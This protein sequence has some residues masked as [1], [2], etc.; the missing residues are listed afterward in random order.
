MRKITE[1]SI[2][3]SEDLTEILLVTY[4]GR[5]IELSPPYKIILD[6]PIPQSAFKNS[7]RNPSP[8][9]NLQ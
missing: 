6:T 5:L 7:Y 2:G 8:L 1:D 4:L 9:V 3:V